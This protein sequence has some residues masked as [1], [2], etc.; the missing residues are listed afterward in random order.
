VTGPIVPLHTQITD[1][2]RAGRVGRPE[3]LAVLC[4]D[5]VACRGRTELGGGWRDDGLAGAVAEA[6]MRGHRGDLDDVHWP[7]L[8]H[9]GS[10]VWPLVLGIAA[11]APTPGVEVARAASAGYDMTAAI[12]DLIAAAGITGIHRT[13]VAG[14]AG[15]AIAAALLGG[16]AR[17]TADAVGLALAV[18][19]GVGQ[20][21]DERAA[22]GAFHRA[23]AAVAGLH[24]ARAARSGMSAP[25]QVLE[26]RSGLVAMLG[27]SDP[28]APA[29][30]AAIVDDTCLRVHPTNGFLQA[31]FEAV[32][33]L[34]ARARGAPERIEVVLHP[35]AIGAL[36][37]RWPRWTI[38]SL[39]PAWVGP[40]GDGAD[41]RFTVVEG[42]VV[43]GAARVRVLGAG[44]ADEQAVDRDFA[45]AGRMGGAT[46]A[47]WRGLGLSDG[48]DV[49]DRLAR[50]FGDEAPFSL[51]QALSTSGSPR[52][53]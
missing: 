5:H 6:A 43:L 33:L 39:R 8:T 1:I 42:D 30:A 9:P 3:H 27:G 48:E 17:R 24:A 21:I 37:E 15:A 7:T 4:A 40:T 44:V 28:V 14:H 35:A 12:A 10:V 2:V 45:V 38:A 26:G 51:A 34:A 25:S 22:A 16:D 53:R 13:S 50:Q 46:L 36:D 11:L 23:S 32:G 31:A 29:V 18:A 47:K 19:G 20:T 41:V 49:V 52:S